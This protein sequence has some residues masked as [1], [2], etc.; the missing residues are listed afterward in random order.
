MIHCGRPRCAPN[1]TKGGAGNSRGE[2]RAAGGRGVLAFYIVSLGIAAGIVGSFVRHVFTQFGYVPGFVSGLYVTLGAA[3]LFSAAQLLYLTILRAYQ[4]TRAPAVYVT[5]G[6][7]QLTMLLLFPA[8][9][10]FPIPGLPDS[11]SRLAPLVYIGVAFAVHAM[12]KFMSFYGALTGPPDHDRPIL[13]WFGLSVLFGLFGVLGFGGWQRAIEGARLKAEM[14]EVT[15]AV[16]S[17]FARARAVKEGAALTGVM[18][19]R[20]QPIMALR[21]ANLEPGLR[22][23][24]PVER[25]YATVTIEG[26]TT[27]V[28][29]SSAAMR[30]DAWTEILV[31]TSYFPADASRYHVYWTRRSEPNWQRILGLRPIVYNLPEQPGAAP[32]P[33]AEVYLSGPSVYVNREAVKG[34]NLLIVVVDGLAAKH[35]SLFGYDRDV[36]PSIDRLGFRAHLFPKMRAPGA[37][38]EIGLSALFSGRDPTLLTD[39]AP[40]AASLTEAVGQ[41]GF[42]TAAFV[43]SGPQADLYGRDWA[44]GFQVFEARPFPDPQKGDADDSGETL[45]RVRA[46]I[47]DHREVPFLCLVRLRTV[48]ELP[49]AGA[50]IEELFSAG[51]QPRDIDRYDSALLRL[52]RQLGALFKYIRDYETRANTAIVVTSTYGVEFSPASTRRVA[53]EHTDAVP[54][55]I[56]TPERRQL[57]YPN[58]A[59]LHDLAYTLAHLATVRLP[60]GSGTTLIP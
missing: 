26:R 2:G 31:P 3:F 23:T 25:V 42:A 45:A 59:R 49:G 54:L 32:P 52:D 47:S 15:A 22:E 17:Q 5:E 36:T 46:W 41:A 20:E 33:P 28:F 11:M 16:G 19:G 51:G 53:D 7:S 8:L 38:P 14:P 60:G 21:F 58:E 57:K 24:N 34:L 4:P 35:L 13:V 6:L 1:D 9:L 44:R 12:F 30:E 10:D 48:A 43:E 27:K 56:E 39:S 40:A 55:I 18:E 37:D 29:Q 50:P